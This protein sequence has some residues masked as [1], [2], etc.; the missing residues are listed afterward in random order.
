MSKLYV[1]ETGNRERDQKRPRIN[2][3]YIKICVRRWLHAWINLCEC[4]V[5]QQSALGLSQLVGSP[6]DLSIFNLS[7][8]SS[9]LNFCPSVNHSPH[10]LLMNTMFSAS[11]HPS[12]YLCIKSPLSIFDLTGTKIK[13]VFLNIYSTQVPIGP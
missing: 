1:V 13:P 12:F 7:K 5:D 9:H 6:T 2:I 11:D 3:G 8:C 4:H 10:P